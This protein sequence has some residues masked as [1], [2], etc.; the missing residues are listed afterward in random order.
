MRSPKVAT[1]RR[2][3][4]VEEAARPSGVSS[5]TENTDTA[6]SSPAAASRREGGGA[7]ATLLMDLLWRCADASRRHVP[8]GRQSK[9]HTAPL[10]QPT[11]RRSPSPDQAKLL[12]GGRAAAGPSAARRSRGEPSTVAT[13]GC[14][15][16]PP[17]RG[18]A[19]QGFF[20]VRASR[21]AV[22]H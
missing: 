21:H 5:G 4:R 19:R 14:A 10:A 15:L 11:A 17:C 13:P 6:P 9:S 2:S 22:A 18:A 12:Q 1:G 3:V 8:S 16:F 7:I 20:G